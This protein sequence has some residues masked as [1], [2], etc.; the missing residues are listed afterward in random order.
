MP[1]I[2]EQTSARPDSVPPAPGVRDLDELLALAPAA[3]SALYQRAS[4]PALDEVR[5]DL[6]G[7]MLATTV[8]GGAAARFA[9]SWASS[10][11]F[12][13]RGKSF[14]P[15]TT[16]EGEGINRVMVD[17][18]R[19]FRFETFIGPSRAGDFDALQLDYDLPE[20]PFFIRPIKDE[21]RQLRDGLYLG[22]AYLSLRGAETLVLYFGLTR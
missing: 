19:L 3:L 11:L 17:R 21:L 8:L 4:V 20:N 18:L 13:W 2:Q 10:N 15:G 16:A 14:M 5:G 12:V 6:R 9:R 7:R 1:E 22:Q